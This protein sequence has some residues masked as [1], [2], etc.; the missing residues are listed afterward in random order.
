MPNEMRVLPAANSG[1]GTP[2]R[3]GRSRGA[4]QKIYRLTMADL[5]GMYPVQRELGSFGSHTGT[6]VVR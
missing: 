5:I 4:L 1:L 2:G 3:P 6:R